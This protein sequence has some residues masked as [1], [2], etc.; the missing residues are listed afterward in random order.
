MATVYANT[1][2]GYVA[3]GN[4]PGWAGARDAS[5]GTTVSDSGASYV[6]GVSAYY[7]R[8]KYNVYRSFFVFD[9]SSISGTV[10]SATF[11]VYGVT[12]SGA[13]IIAVQATSDASSLATGDF[14]AI[15]GWSS[16]D[17]EGNVT[18]H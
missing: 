6:L 11:K 9:T 12:N 10:S 4:S 8:G 7:A 16:G 18:A 2:D 17:N 15:Q 13:D 1:S 3:Y 14:N 5:T